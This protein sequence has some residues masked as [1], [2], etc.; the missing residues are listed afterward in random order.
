M[1]EERSPARCAEALSEEAAESVAFIFAEASDL[2]ALCLR[3]K[4]EAAGVAVRRSVGFELEEPPETERES[5]VDRSWEFWRDG[6]ALAERPES[7]DAMLCLE[8]LLAEELG[9]AASWD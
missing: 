4:G 1:E 6:D 9:K 3:V 2:A 8:E 7:L 5:E